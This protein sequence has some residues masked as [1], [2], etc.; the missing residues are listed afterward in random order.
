MLP[1]VRLA[2]DEL[3]AR[4][5]RQIAKDETRAAIFRVAREELTKRGFAQASL[6]EIA[7]RANVATGTVAL[8]FGDKLGL[9]QAMLHADVEVV[10]K[11]AFATVPKKP[12]AAQ[13]S[14]I[15][16][17]VFT[18]YQENEELSGILLQAS[19]L[20]E[21]PWRGRFVLQAGFAH[22]RLSELVTHAIDRK[23]LRSDVDE[24]LVA[25]SFLSFHYFALIS[26]AQDAIEDPVDLVDRL[27]AVQLQAVK[28]GK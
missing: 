5:P 14:H 2:P 23:E 21:E 13:L 28:R 3:A 20:C 8:H 1:A 18:Y 4:R 16:R 12:L 26:W 10:L 9:V 11:D 15:A 6:R 22:A 17:C 27:M 25:L 19:L 24:S 7:R